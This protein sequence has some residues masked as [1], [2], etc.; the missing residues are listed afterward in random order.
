MN[1][2][3]LMIAVTEAKAAVERAVEK[4]PGLDLPGRLRA[5][6]AVTRNHWMVTDDDARFR[7]GVGG[8]L[9]TA[10]EDEKVR[11]TAELA[12][13]RALNAAMTGVPVDFETAFGDEAEPIG[14]VGI[15][16][17]VRGSA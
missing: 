7:A 15:W 3:L 12:R 17:D 10:S 14:M 1:D 5:S 4:D 13:L 16:H 2:N 11:I 9:A 8:V 6:F